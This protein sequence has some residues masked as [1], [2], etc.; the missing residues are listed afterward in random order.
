MALFGFGRRAKPSS[1]LARY[2]LALGISAL[3]LLGTWLMLPLLGPRIFLFFYGAVVLSALYGGYGPGLLATLFALVSTS[4]FFLPPAFSFKLDG[5]DLLVLLIFGLVALATGALADQRRRAELREREQAEWFRVTLASIGDAVIVTDRDGVVTFMNPVAEALTGWSQS[6]VLGQDCAAV[7]RIINADTRAVV[8]SPVTR[9]LREGVVVGL[10]NHTLLVAR[11]GSE[12]PIDDSG[13]PVRL[14]DGTMRGVVLVFRDV[15]AREQ[16]EADRRA[17]LRSE[18][19]ARA[20]AEAARSQ[21]DAILASVTDGFLAFDREW[22]F[23]Y[24]NA[25]G[26][27]TLGRSPAALLGKNLW[28]EF[29]ELA[30]TSFG[31]LYRRAMEEN[32]VL[33]LEDYYPPFD[34]WFLARAY[35]SPAGLTLYFLN[36][37]ARVEAT[38]RATQL[39]EAEQQARTRAEAL[40]IENERLYRDAREAVGVRD[41]FLSIAAH[42]LKTPLTTLIGNLQ[43]LQRR[44]DQRLDER[45]RRNLQVAAAQAGRLNRMVQSLLDVSRIEAGQLAIERAP[46]DIVA[47]A[48][49]VIDETR[50]SADGRELRFVS[51]ETAAPVLGDELRLEQALQNLLQNA[52][53]Y[54]PAGAPVTVEVTQDAERVRLAVRD[55]G[56]GVPAAALPYLFQRF[57]RASNVDERQVSGMGIGLYVVREIVT[58]HGGTVSVASQEGAGSTFVIELPMA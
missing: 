11:D 22:C 21:V 14:A 36:V 45:E 57:Y 49:R 6:E 39:L 18:Q 56:V 32:V 38:Q 47:L 10:A 9:V 26:A 55:Q 19:G 58:L 33:E 28:E 30:E 53:K 13:A 31:R 25:E 3:A 16:A 46:V 43:L 1:V 51:R 12:R 4:Y 20:E 54:S 17:L 27:R 40:A 7:F 23:T 42:E 50:A 44:M 5:A 34:A 8:E 35:P 15:T 2:G 24:V 52:L 48:R 29:P 37:T 41:Q